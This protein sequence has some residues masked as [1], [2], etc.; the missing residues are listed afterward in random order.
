MTW[1]NP[2]P[3]LTQLRGQLVA[4]AAWTGGTATV[5]YPE[6]TGLTSATF[7][8]AVLSELRPRSTPYAEGAGGI[9]GGELQIVI[10]GTDTVGNMEA[11]GRSILDQLL[12]QVTG[13]VWQP[14]EAGLSSD[15][16]PG[17]IAGNAAVRSVTLRLPWGLT[18]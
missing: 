2:P 6:L 5:H 7:P 11:L 8:L 12:A 16:S 15:P 13:I 18:P 4:C 1:T 17:K 14:A 3:I 9:A 10:Y